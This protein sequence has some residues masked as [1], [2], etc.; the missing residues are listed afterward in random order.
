MFCDAIVTMNSGSA[1]ETI[2]AGS[3]MGETGSSAGRTLTPERS[4]GPSIATAITAAAIA[5]GAAQG[6]ETRVSSAHTI[7]TGAAT[8]GISMTALAGATQIGSST[9]ASIALASAGGIAA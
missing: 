4:P 9:P 1:I 6:R 3:R 2:A 8:H 7:T 5:P